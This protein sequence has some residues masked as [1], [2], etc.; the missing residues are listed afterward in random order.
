[1]AY[2]R[3]GKRAVDVVASLA[4]IVVLSVVLVLLALAARLS[5]PGPAIFRQTRVGRDGRPFTLLKFRSMP[6]DTGDIA[7]DRIDAVAIRPFGRLIRRTNLDEL[8]QLFNILRGDMSLIGPRPSLP[9]QTELVELRRANGALGCRPGLTGLAQVNSFD[10]MTIAQKA[11]WDGRYAARI[12]L[13][14][15]IAIVWRTFGYLRRP[16]PTY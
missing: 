5:S 15:D 7:S 10:G 2:A 9:S 4:V 11:A 13:V 6:V 1:M 8:P 14:R 16:P 3:F 12:T